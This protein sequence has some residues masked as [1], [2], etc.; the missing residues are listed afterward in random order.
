MSE[1]SLSTW[2]ILIWNADINWH[3][4]ALYKS[5]KCHMPNNIHPMLQ[6]RKSCRWQRQA[7]R[8]RDHVRFREEHHDFFRSDTFR[9]YET[10]F[11][12]S[13]RARWKKYR[14]VVEWRGY[15]PISYTP[16]ELLEMGRTRWRER[17]REEEDFWTETLHGVFLS[18]YCPFQVRHKVIPLMI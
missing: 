1:V 12:S 16:V 7:F 2:S 15:W 13:G 9:I 17:G 8:I 3:P 14:V 6:R 5:C 10:H 11:F 18:R 4:G